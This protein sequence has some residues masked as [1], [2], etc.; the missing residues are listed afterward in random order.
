MPLGDIPALP[1]K[2]LQA[3]NR[4]MEDKQYQIKATSSLFHQDKADRVNPDF[5]LYTLNDFLGHIQHCV[6]ATQRLLPPSGETEFYAALSKE[7]PLIVDFI[8]IIHDIEVKQLSA[9]LSALQ[10]NAHELSVAN[11]VPF[12]RLLYRSLL[13]VYYIGADGVSRMYRA[14]YRRILDKIPS[15]NKDSLK[16]LS[17]EAI[18]EWHFI[19]NRVYP[20]LY[21]LVLRMCATSLLSPQQLF[22]ANGSKV[23]SWLSLTPKEIL[24][25][26][27][28]DELDSAAPVVASPEPS[29]PRPVAKPEVP[30]KVLRG[31]DVLERLFPEAGWKNLDTMPDF[32]PYFQSILHF[33]DGFIQLSPQNPLHQ[34]MVLFG[35][36]EQLF[37]GLRLIK[38]KPLDNTASAGDNADIIKILEDWILYQEA[39]FEKIFSNDLKAYTHQIYTQPD[40]KK[41]PYGRKLLANLYSLTRSFFMP[42]FNVYVFG[43]SK[44][45][46]DDRLPPFYIRV[47]HLKRLLSRYAADIEIAPPKME[48]SSETALSYILNP[49]APYK[50]DIANSVSRR[51]DAL[52]GGKHAK[53]RTNAQLIE[54]TLDILYVLDWWINDK[55]SFAYREPPE[56]LYRV[57]EP[58][59]SVPAFGLTP[60]TDVDSLF[61][62]HLKDAQGLA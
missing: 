42:W 2:E 45:S 55:D 46:K 23:L 31:L 8:G 44:L 43:S 51:L 17:T 57:V 21:P 6:A 62:R 34:T 39:V 16:A 33:G 38:F 25:L 20:G 10:K 32:G 7:R 61:V 49:W 56:Y 35:I 26:R 48:Q 14:L 54:Y 47:A 37:Q 36:L 59:S 12:V 13:R 22:Y 27:A 53:G 52:C 50:F 1:E 29:E 40:F 11:L 5:V 4:L 58:G 60:R 18:E 41:T 30:E 15:T 3:I 9:Q 19:F 28:E 24:I